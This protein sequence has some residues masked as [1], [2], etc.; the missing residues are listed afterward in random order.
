MIQGVC[1]QMTNANTIT[2]NCSS[3]GFK[4]RFSATSSCKGLNLLII[5]STPTIVI[6][7]DNPATTDSHISPI[8]IEKL[9]AASST[10]VKNS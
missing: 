4:P 2:R 8:L 3:L 5:H 10:L 9:S 6:I 7:N 1:V